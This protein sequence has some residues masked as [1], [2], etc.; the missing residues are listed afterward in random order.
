VGRHRWYRRSTRTVTCRLGELASGA[1]IDDEDIDV[2]VDPSLAGRTVRNSASVASEPSGP[3][4]QPAERIP[5][6]NQDTAD[7]DVAQTA[8]LRITETVTP[9]V[10]AAAR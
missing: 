4:L 5:S 8:D 2:R 6:S 3:L 7:M 1:A 9:A 10:A